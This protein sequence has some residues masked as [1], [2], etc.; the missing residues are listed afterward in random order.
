MRNNKLITFLA[1]HFPTTHILKSLVPQ[2]PQHG[3]TH[4]L[5]IGGVVIKK[6]KYIYCLINWK[7]TKTRHD[8]TF[9]FVTAKNEK[10]YQS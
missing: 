1:P 2:Q 8:K 3:P 9:F 7:Q 10:D 5:L 6:K 4:K